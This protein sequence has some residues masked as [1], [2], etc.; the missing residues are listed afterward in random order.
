MNSTGGN[1]VLQLLALGWEW[2]DENEDSDSDDEEDYGDESSDEDVLPGED[3][4]GPRREMVIVNLQR[5]PLDKH[6]TLRFHIECD[7]MMQMLMTE[8]GLVVPD[9]SS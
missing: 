3:A 8:L 7:G 5:T 2:P 4:G 9:G 1:F 6:C